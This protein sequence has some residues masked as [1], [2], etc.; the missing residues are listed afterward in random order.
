MDYPGSGL[1]AYFGRGRP[2]SVYAWGM[3]GAR[4]ELGSYRHALADAQLDELDRQIAA[5][6]LWRLPQPEFLTLDVPWVGISQDDA[7]GVVHEKAWSMPSLPAEV[8]ALLGWIRPLI[9]EIREHPWCVLS[10]AASWKQSTQRA[11]E[12]LR[13][14]FSFKNVGRSP[15]ELVGPARQGDKDSYLTL[16]MDRTATHPKAR[17][18]GVPA[19]GAL[20]V[21]NS[22]ILPATVGLFSTTAM[23]ATVRIEPGGS[24]KFEVVLPARI[25]PGTYRAVLLFNSVEREF[26]PEGD[27][28][29]LD[30]GELAPS[31]H[32][33][34]LVEVDPKLSVFGRLALEFGP[35]LVNP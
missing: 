23:N 15:L 25:A 11:G 16:V 24:A 2:C 28:E 7:T 30:D 9:D 17:K 12:P 20:R 6:D 35:I 1:S 26:E 18:T 5:I 33:R 21:P 19:G 10:G 4:R 13:F 14:E 31:A 29:I 22:A 34:V 3:V 8:R 27:V 32:P